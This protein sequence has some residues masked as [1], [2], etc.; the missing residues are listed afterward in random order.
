[1]DPLVTAF[2]SFETDCDRLHRAG[3]T[4]VLKQTCAGSPLKVRLTRGVTPAGGLG[5]VTSTDSLAVE[6]LAGIGEMSKVIWADDSATFL[7]PG[8]GLPSASRIVTVAPW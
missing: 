2:A 6:P 4:V 7:N 8:T 3:P 1:L 5:I